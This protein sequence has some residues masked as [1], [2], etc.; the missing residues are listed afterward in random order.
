MTNRVNQA[1][2]AKLHDVSR[3]TVT[4]WKSRGWLV[5]D[6]DLIDVDSSNERFKR[7]RAAGVTPTVT[8]EV[9]G[10]T[11]SFVT[12]TRTRM[13]EVGNKGFP[14]STRT[15]A[16]EGVFAVHKKRVF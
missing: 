11:V 16:R 15:C 4:M 6:G 13:R 14:T 7:Y 5:F 1:D 10:N 12:N 2:F 8:H 9:T 3:K